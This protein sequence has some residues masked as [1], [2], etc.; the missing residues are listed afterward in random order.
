MSAMITMGA[1]GALQVPDEPI[2]PFIQGDGTGID[3]WPAARSVLD[4]AAAKH[5][6][7]IAWKEVLA[8]QRA[9]DQTGDWLPTR[10]SRPSATTSSE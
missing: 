10:P 9:Y 6:R 5:G 1:D 8:G 3:I 2:I 4:A 7:R